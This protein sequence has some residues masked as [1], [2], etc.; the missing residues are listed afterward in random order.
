MTYDFLNTRYTLYIIH[1]TSKLVIRFQDL[2][3]KKLH[4]QNGYVDNFMNILRKI[5]ITRFIFL[6][7]VIGHTRY[8]NKIHCR[9]YFNTLLNPKYIYIYITFMIYKNQT[10]E[11]SLKL[12][13]I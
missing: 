4:V 12:F 7:Y 5:F 11:Y 3:T 8:E 2:N 6:Y 10:S 13:I 1:Y 9:L